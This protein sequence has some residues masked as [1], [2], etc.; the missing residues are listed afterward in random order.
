[1]ARLDLAVDGKVPIRD[2]AEP[3]VM[4]AATVPV[5]ST[6]GSGEVPLQLRRKIR[7]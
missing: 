4:V 5:E 6:V 1:M 7:H 3:D 2:R